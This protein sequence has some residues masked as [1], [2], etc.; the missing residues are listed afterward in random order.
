MQPLVGYI[1]IVV[2][3]CHSTLYQNTIWSTTCECISNYLNTI[4]VIFYEGL[5]SSESFTQS[6]YISVIV[7]IFRNTLFLCHFFLRIYLFFD[8]KWSVLWGDLA[9]HFFFL[10]ITLSHFWEEMRRNDRKYYFTQTWI[11]GHIH[12]TLV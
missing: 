9:C 11:R 7:T 12:F 1:H 5:F 4:P 2:L 8:E 10:C 6:T 3:C